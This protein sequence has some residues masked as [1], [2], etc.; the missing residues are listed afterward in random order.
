MQTSETE[1]PRL[2][3]DLDIERFVRVQD[4]KVGTKQQQQESE[5]ERAIRELREGGNP[6]EWMW[7]IFPR[8]SGIGKHINSVFY[9]VGSMK[10][11]KAFLAHPILGPRLHAAT[12]A[13]LENAECDL[14]KIFSNPDQERFNSSM[15]LF[16][17]ACLLTSDELFLRVIMKFWGGV[18]DEKTVRIM[19]SWQTYQS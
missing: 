14:G 9:G 2:S 18:R 7:F 19:E 8:V 10:E 17:Q 13:V 5:Y 16:A 11:A 6:C 15:T 4:R 3:P 12:E 1:P